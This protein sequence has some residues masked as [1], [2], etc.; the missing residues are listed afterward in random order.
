MRGWPTTKGTDILALDIACLR[1]L[2]DKVLYLLRLKCPI[3]NLFLI[4]VRDSRS[5]PVF[6][7]GANVRMAINRVVSMI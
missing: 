4:V 6:G 5:V 7:N 1:F 2:L 3:L